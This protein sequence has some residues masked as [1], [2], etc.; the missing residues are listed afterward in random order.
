[1]RTD[2]DSISG[3]RLKYTERYTK[4][5]FGGRHCYEIEALQILYD[6]AGKRNFYEK[7]KCDKHQYEYRKYING[8]L[9][10][11]HIENER[12]N[13]EIHLFENCLCWISALF[14]IFFVRSN[15]YTWC[16]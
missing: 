9:V 1:M 6:A 7:S 12:E 8:K 2:F 13:E 5:G 10:F 11:I 15:A 14:L 16:G 3:F 4:V